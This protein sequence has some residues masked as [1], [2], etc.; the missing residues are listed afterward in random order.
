MNNLDLLIQQ[1]RKKPETIEFKDVIDLIDEFY[2]FTPVQ[3]S[4]GVGDE[5]FTNSA[6]ENNGSCKIF[7]FARMH[8]LNEEE[9]L[10]CFGS[11]YR[12]DVLQHPESNDHA[13]IRTFMDH[14]WKHIRFLNTALHPK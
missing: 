6:G 10:N 14:G 1:L 7:S 5:K 4:N 13:N 2:E 11:Y 8:G 12:E 3:F 9:T